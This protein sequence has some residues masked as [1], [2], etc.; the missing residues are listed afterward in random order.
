MPFSSGSSQPKD[1][2]QFSLKLIPAHLSR[3]WEEPWTAG[4]WKP[5]FQ[6]MGLLEADGTVRE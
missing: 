3:G 1:K 6:M 5:V 4:L 2:T